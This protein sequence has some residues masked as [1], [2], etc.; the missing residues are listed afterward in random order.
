MLPRGS[1]AEPRPA[2][3]VVES[4]VTVFHHGSPLLFVKSG[5]GVVCRLSY[6]VEESCSRT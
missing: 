5:G 2:N 4:L 1:L 6:G 3:L